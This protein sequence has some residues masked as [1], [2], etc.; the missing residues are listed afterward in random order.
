MAETFHILG[1]GLAGLM[2]AQ[3]LRAEGA[4]TVVYGD[5]QTNTPP[6]GLVHLFAGRTFRRDALELLAFEKAVE[7][8]RAEPLAVE[9]PVRRKLTQGDRLWRSLEGLEL[10]GQFAPGHASDGWVEYRPGFAIASQLLEERLRQELDVKADS[11]LRDVGTVP[12]PRILA[13]GHAM[14][15]LMSEVAWDVLVGRTVEASPQ[16]LPSQITIGLGVHVAPRPA[17]T[18]VVVGGRSSPKGEA[19]DELA[20]ARELLGE[21]VRKESIWTGTRCTPARDRRPVLGWT[22]QGFAFCGFGSRALF[23]LPLCLDIATG[24]LLRKEPILPEL[25]YCRLSDGDGALAL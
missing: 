13:A 4:E 18:T 1:D 17:G 10:P 20:L 21:P 14:P 11:A 15:E 23:W 7:F 6:V 22:D 8:W 19:K 25:H 3:R 2:L 24:A 5:G 16:V 9:L 12:E